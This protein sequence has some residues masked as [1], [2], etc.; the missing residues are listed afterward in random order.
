MAILES[1]AEG[2]HP[3][4]DSGLDGPQGLAGGL[5]DLLLSASTI[6]GHFDGRA[7]SLGQ[8]TQS[9]A[10]TA[11]L[12]FGFQMSGGRIRARLPP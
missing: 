9:K 3:S 12:I 5:S 4:S 2:K 7:L 6:E 11:G 1:V 8:R 10:Q